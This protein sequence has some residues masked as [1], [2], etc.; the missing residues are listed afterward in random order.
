[1]ALKK[2]LGFSKLAARHL[3]P[4]PIFFLGGGGGGGGVILFSFTGDD[5]W[6]EFHEILGKL[7]KFVTTG[8]QLSN[9]PYN[10]QSKF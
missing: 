7:N 1:M 6:E 3:V 10:Q 5:I 9:H 8:C 2:H 4:S